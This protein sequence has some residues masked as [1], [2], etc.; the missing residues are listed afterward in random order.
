[1][2]S[3]AARYRS[4]AVEVRASADIMPDER[5]RQDILMA[6][7]VWERLATF[8]ERPVPKPLPTYTRQPNPDR[9]WAAVGRSSPCLPMWKP[10]RTCWP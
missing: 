8:A 2:E 3:R 1:M 10:I 4:I 9:F 6:A 5:V 7:E